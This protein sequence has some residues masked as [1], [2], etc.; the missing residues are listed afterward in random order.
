MKP[1]TTKPHIYVLM[2]CTGCGKGAVGR[3][4]AELMDAEI[5]SVDSMKV[6]RRMDIGTAKPS[7]EV[8][9]GVRHHLID[10]VEP[11]ESFSAAEFVEMADAA[12]A[13]I[14][15]RGKR[16]LAVGGTTL[17]LKS[18]VEGLF[19]G[20]SADP[21]LRE[22]LEADIAE[23]G[24]AAMHAELT[25]VDP[26]AADRIHP[27]DERRIVR[28]LEV[29]RIT[30][31]PL[32]QLQTQWDAGPGRYP[33]TFTGLRRP[34]EEQSHRINQRVKRMMELGL[35]EEVRSLMAE[36]TG[37]SKQASYAIGYAEI[38]AHLNGQC[39]LEDAVER[40]KI[41]T[42]QFAKHQRTWHRRFQNVRWTD[43]APDQDLLGTADRIAEELNEDRKWDAG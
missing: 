35:V 42:R 26:D 10:V 31:R 24:L 34:R 4:L 28:A 38:I 30:G 14:A 3:R 8:R 11:S 23:R 37:M 36:P 13:D 41:N 19:E 43:L 20:P 22:T 17:Y 1:E 12:V 21:A 27:N 5:I 33:A 6:Y 25:K 32:S 2:G 16:V 18:F 15:A 29:Y 39:S 40:V 9:E 7:A